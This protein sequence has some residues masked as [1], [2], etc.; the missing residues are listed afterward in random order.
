MY[1]IYPGSFEL[2]RKLQHKNFNIQKA[3]LCLFT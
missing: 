2:E 3:G 1:I